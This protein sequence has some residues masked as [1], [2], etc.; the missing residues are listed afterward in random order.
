MDGINV[1]FPVEVLTHLSLHLVDLPWLEHALGDDWPWVS[2]DH[3]SL[4][5]LKPNS[6]VLIPPHGGIPTTF[7]AQGRAE[8]IDEFTFVEAGIVGGGCEECWMWWI[9]RFW[10]HDGVIGGDSHS[11]VWS[12]IY[13]KIPQGNVD[14]TCHGKKKTQDKPEKINEKLTWHNLSQIT[15]WWGSIT[16]ARQ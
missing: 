11:V 8:G 14:Q 13:C 15:E 5:I 16:P 7:F 12:V 3:Q 1:E 9:C 4:I 6:P 2:P 10:I